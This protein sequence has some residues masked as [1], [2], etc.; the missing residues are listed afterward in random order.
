MSDP[1]LRQ[2]E[3]EPAA[4]PQQP[5]LDLRARVY[6]IAAGVVVVA[7]GAFVAFLL[8]RT[9]E[10]SWK[11][12]PALLGDL[13]EEVEVG[14][15]RIRPPRDYRRLPAVSA[16]GRPGDSVYI[17]LGPARADGAVPRLRVLLLTPPPGEAD[18]DLEDILDKFLKGA[19]EHWRAWIQE[20]VE[21]GRVNG[22]KFVRTRW[23]GI[24]IATGQPTRGFIYLARD[25]ET[26][27]QISSQDVEPDHEQP[28]RLAETAALTFRKP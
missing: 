13:G 8:L 17:W 11:P 15:Y 20:S 28:L 27:I 6:L 24:S 23:S 1:E 19:R 3:P 12:D 14:D 2:P 25:G 10:K 21:A 4:A 9:G 26:V 22:L 18:N 7:A 16:Q 5:R